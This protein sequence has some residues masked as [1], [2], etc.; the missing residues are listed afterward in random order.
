[1]A[2]NGR[3]GPRDLAAAVELFEKAATQGHS[4]AMFALGALHGGGHGLPVDRRTAQNW[5]RAAAMLGHGQAQLMLGRYLASGA[6]DELNPEEAREWL[7]RAV[8]Q[9]VAD[10]QHDLAELSLPPQ[11]SDSERTWHSEQVAAPRG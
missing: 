9:G 10:A 3:G 7:E 4:G 1:M 5:F 11:R 8:V 6:G 2:V